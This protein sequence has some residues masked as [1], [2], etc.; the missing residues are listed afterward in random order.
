MPLHHQQAHARNIIVDEAAGLHL[1]WHYDRIFI[2]P[3]P[4]YFYSSQFWTYLQGLSPAP[5]PADNRKFNDPYAAA[6]GFMRSYYFLI[7]FEHPTY[8][9]FC[10]FIEQFNDISDADTCRR[11]HYG[12]LRLTRINRTSLFRKGRL[13]YFHIY[14]Q[15]GPTSAISSPPSS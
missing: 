15:W 4:A 10:R 5:N 8:A 6:I 14:P 11:Y 2:K 7:Q 3:I 9:E 12:E 13:A 1:V